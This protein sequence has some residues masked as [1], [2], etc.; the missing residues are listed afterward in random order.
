MA[1][2]TPTAEISQGNAEYV[3]YDKEPKRGHVFW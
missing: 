2:T 3:S 1:S